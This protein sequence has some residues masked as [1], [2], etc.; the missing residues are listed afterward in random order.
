MELVRGK[1]IFNI[2]KELIMSISHIAMQVLHNFKSYLNPSQHLVSLRNQAA[3]IVMMSHVK[4]GNA[5]AL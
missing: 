2:K 5:G 1:I 4:A 3:D